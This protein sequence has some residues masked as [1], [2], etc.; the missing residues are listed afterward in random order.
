MSNRYGA[1]GLAGYPAT[2]VWAF[3]EYHRISGNAH[4]KAM[5]GPRGDVLEKD[6][7]RTIRRWHSALR[8][9]R[10]VVHNLLSKYGFSNEYFRKWCESRNLP[11]A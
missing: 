6:D 4:R 9:R 10:S 8:A 3:F 5:L 2:T 7:A 11:L 1:G